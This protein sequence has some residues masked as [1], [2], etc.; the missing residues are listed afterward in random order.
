MNDLQ[1]LD[2]VH[3]SVRNPI[4]KGATI[5]AGGYKWEMPP[6]NLRQLREYQ[7]AIKDIKKD[8][9]LAFFT[10][11]V[12]AIT[13]ALSRNYPAITVE[14]CL[15]VIDAGNFQTVLKIMNGI[16]GVVAAGEVQAQQ[17]LTSS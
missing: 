2:V 4:I 13:A 5:E 3:G 6:M 11:S 8:D 9:E 7:D 14:H 17:T 15:D 16:S 1:P 10:V 12:K